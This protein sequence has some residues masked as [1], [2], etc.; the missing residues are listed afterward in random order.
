[1]KLMGIKII[2]PVAFALMTVLP[3]SAFADT[4]DIQ[5][6]LRDVQVYWL[7]TPTSSLTLAGKT[8]AED[9]SCS[10]QMTLTDGSLSVFAQGE[11]LIIPFVLKKSD[12]EMT[13][14]LESCRADKE[15]LHIVFEEKNENEFEKRRKFQMTFLKRQGKGLSLI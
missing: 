6:C 7:N 2:V 12:A 14:T 10:L 3:Q 11:P 4:T 15:K 9:T 8:R 5:Q 13:R 1:M